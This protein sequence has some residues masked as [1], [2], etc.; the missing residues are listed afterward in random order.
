MM[1][2]IY[3]ELLKKSDPTALKSIHAKY[4]RR[5]FW[6]GKRIIDDEFIVENLM[7]DTFLQLWLYREKIESPMHILFFLQ[8]VMK[9]S[10]KAYYF[11][12]RNKFLKK[13]D[14]TALKSIHAKY[15]RRIFWLGKR[16]IDDEFIVENLM[17]DTFLQLWLY[18]EKIESPMHILFFLQFV[19][20]RSCKAYY[21][22]PRNKFL[23]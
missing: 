11:Q 13:S 15:N 1:P 8:F 4:N 12:P 2:Q 6:L 17:Q 9:R 3:F 10:C 20:K 18:R 14:P 5:I 23:K 22:Q 16:I 7:Q 19:M 21:F